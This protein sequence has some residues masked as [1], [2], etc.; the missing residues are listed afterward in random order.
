MA[1]VG[2]AARPAPRR[3]H[4]KSTAGPPT[5]SGSSSAPHRQHASSRKHPSMKQTT[6]MENRQPRRKCAAAPPANEVKAECAATREWL[7][8]RGGH[9]VA[10]DLAVLD[11]Y[12][13]GF[14]EQ[15]HNSAPPGARLRAIKMLSQ[16]RRKRHCNGLRTKPDRTTHLRPCF[17]AP[18][19][20]LS[21]HPA[22]R[23][24]TGAGSGC[25]PEPAGWLHTDPSAAAPCRSE[26][27]R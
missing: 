9:N 7:V 10:D 8:T 20:R 24:G 12:T 22:R 4:R 17:F 26:G 14:D 25:R 18:T 3:T 11:A 19:F 13:A 23:L 6:A 5:V 15:G 1:S 16:M 21:E 2:A 27:N